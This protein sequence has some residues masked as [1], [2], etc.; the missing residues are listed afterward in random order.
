MT[1]GPRRIH[2][3]QARFLLGLGLLMVLLGVIF[4]A[5]LYFHLQRLLRSEVSNQADLVLAQVDAV[6]NFV[7]SSLRPR[8]LSLLPADQFVIEAM[9]T[10]F[11]SRQVMERLGDALPGHLY[12]RVSDQPRN[13]K[14]RAEGLELELLAYFRENPEAET[15][16]GLR[17]LG[18]EELFIKA[19]PVRFE[20]SCLRC[21][22]LPEEAPREMLASYGDRKS[23]V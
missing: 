20:A 15:W 22:G 3:L 6:Q 5:S 4:G 19:R 18:A 17:H 12:R 7:R 10:S 16:T 8:I 1:L 21:H 14:F 9:S 13:P 11:V 23:V 2:S